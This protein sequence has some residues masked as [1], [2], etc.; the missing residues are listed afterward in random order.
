[1]STDSEQAWNWVITDSQR[2]AAQDILTEFKSK[3][4]RLYFAFGEL[5]M[6]REMLR[7]HYENS[8]DPAYRDVPIA[9]AYQTNEDPNNIQLEPIAEMKQ[10]DMIDALQRGG[11]F[12]N[13]NTNALI[14]FIYHL[15]DEN[16]RA[17]IAHALGLDQANRLESDLF[18]DVRLIRRAII[19]NNSELTQSAHNNLKVLG[20]L[21]EITPGELNLTNATPQRIVLELN[22]LQLRATPS[23]SEN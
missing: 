21:D 8:L 12:E 5:G 15:W 14:V 7:N 4:S 11:E 17:K 6:G 20:S 22:S 10:G 23:K 1:M 2:K 19:H 18:G 9:M 3:V 16:Y 13:L